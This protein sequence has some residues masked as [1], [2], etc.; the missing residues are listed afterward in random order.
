[1]ET[2]SSVAL[3]KGGNVTM[4]TDLPDGH[5]PG[6]TPVL[7]LAHGAGNDC[8]SAFLAHFAGALASAGIAVVRFNF[9]YKER[10]GTRPPDRA[11]VLADAMQDV[12]VAQQ[13][14]TGAPPAPL[15]LGGKSMGSRVAV[16]LVAAGRVPCSGLVLLGFPL[17]KPGEPGTDRA[18]NLGSVRVPTLFVQG[19][20]DPFCELPLLRKVRTA[21]KIPGALLEIDGGGH[22]FEL[23]KSRAAE[24]SAALDRATKGIVQFLGRVLARDRKPGKGPSR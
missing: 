11:E 8:R 9:P 16:S 22:S 2:C 10:T 15:F 13:R 24:Q 14:V 18:A 12:V 5:V 7:V 20:R 19:T 23:P 3:S 4:V 17:H 1:M 6:R 21:T